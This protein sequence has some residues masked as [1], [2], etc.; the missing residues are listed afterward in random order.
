M[1]K[2]FL[3]VILFS[4]STPLWADVICNGTLKDRSI[5]DNVKV[6]QTCQLNQ[7]TI[8]GNVMV[9]RGATLTMMQSKIDGNLESKGRFHKITATAN[10]IDGNIQ[11][12]EGGSATI[13]QNRIEGNI[14][15]EKNSGTLSVQSNTVDGNLVC[16]ENRSAPT[17]GQN[18]VE[19]NKEGQCRNL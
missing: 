8:K 10:N 5:D 16:K 2:T 18:R 6:V 15:L 3:T 14:E 11:L 12:K 1:K 17:G 4:L 19:G 9:E 7:V 13:K